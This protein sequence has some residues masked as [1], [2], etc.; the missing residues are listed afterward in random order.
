MKRPIRGTVNLVLSLLAGFLGLG[1]V[2]YF[3]GWRET[4]AA[5]RALN[6]AGIASVTGSVALG[7]LMWVLSW[8]AILRAYGIRIPWGTMAGA[9]LSCFAVSYLTPTLY[10][11]GEPVRGLLV[12]TPG[13]PPATRVF[14]TIIVERFLGGLSMVAFMLVGGFHAITAP[15]IPVAQ[16]R[17]LIGGLAFVTFWILA[18]LANFALNLKWVSRLL[19]ALGVAVPR[20]RS[21]LERASAKVSET[22]DEVSYAFT[23]HWRGTLAAFVVQSAATL[24]V[25]M[26]PQVF[27][28]FAIG[29]SF[30]VSQLSVFFTFSIL[31]GFFLWIT[32]GGLGTSE[33]ATLG[34][35]HLMA[36]EIA[37]GEAVA[38]SLIF[39]FAE[40][41]FVGIGL[42]YLLQRGVRLLGRGLTVQQ[43]IQQSGDAA[44]RDKEH[45]PSA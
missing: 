13:G 32:P 7:V 31:M 20:W 17:M 37:K 11:G 28:G 29:R 34:V 18:G 38:Y 22:E 5:M 44:I 30:D 3:A 27:F 36:P 9:R 35:F 6:A 15:S 14:A 25:Y 12:I 26:R 41:V 16:K 10:F 45:P 21:R 43:V 1:A 40:A 23:R 4:F 8:A 39:K 42:A 19:R 24:L 33:A 2:L